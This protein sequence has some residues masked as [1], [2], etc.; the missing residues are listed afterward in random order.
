L[1]VEQAGSIAATRTA[2]VRD[3]RDVVC[4][5]MVSRSEE[6][7]SARR[8]ATLGKRRFSGQTISPANDF[9]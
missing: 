6:A 5:F 4:L 1:E 8:R 7:G 9:Y 3:K 2:A